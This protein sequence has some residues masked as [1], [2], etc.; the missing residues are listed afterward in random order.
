MDYRYKNSYLPAVISVFFS[1]LAAGL[2][3]ENSKENK[4]NKMIIF[5]GTIGSICTSIY[6]FN[7]HYNKIYN[8]KK[9]LN[10]R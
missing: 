5:I 6:F 10:N 9:R 4:N 7:K 1:G 2:S 3:I 8:Y